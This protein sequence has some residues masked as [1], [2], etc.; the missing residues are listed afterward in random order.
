VSFQTPTLS[1]LEAIS[2]AP[3]RPKIAQAFG[4]PGQVLR[5]KLRGDKHG[6]EVG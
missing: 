4:I 1:E 5:V 6:L 3:G 2:R